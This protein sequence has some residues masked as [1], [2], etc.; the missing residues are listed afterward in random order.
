VE[1]RRLMNW[2]RLLTWALNALLVLLIVVIL[3]FF[4]AYTFVTG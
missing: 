1:P 3:L 4:A 2:D